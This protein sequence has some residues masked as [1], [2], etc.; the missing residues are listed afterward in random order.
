MQGYRFFCNKLWNA[1]RFARDYLRDFS[2]Q[3]I[4]AVSES[5]SAKRSPSL[6]ATLRKYCSW[7]EKSS[8][9]VQNG[10]ALTVLNSRLTDFSY[11]NGYQ[12]SDCDFEV[13]SC[14]RFGGGNCDKDLKSYPH[15]QRWR[16]HLLYHCSLKQQ[17]WQVKL[18]FFDA[19][20]NAKNYSKFLSVFF[21]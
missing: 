3:D 5:A 12:L 4:T 13:F 11:L 17:I 21:F 14:L 10:N 6:D 16:K 2:P 15:L 20:T 8:V 1:V 7:M 9:T 18:G 19:L